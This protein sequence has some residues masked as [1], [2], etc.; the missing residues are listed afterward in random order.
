MSKNRNEEAWEALFAKWEIPARVA[1]EGRFLISADQIREYREPRLMAK[2]D[3]RVNLPQ[4]F[5]E[6]G[7]A[8]LPVS[9]GDY[10]IGRLRRIAALRR[11]S[12][13]CAA[14]RCPLRWKAFRRQV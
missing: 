5:A 11:T 3:H 4:I 13:R 10:V 2:F 1:A 7:L 12:R 9:R 6:N 8:I 14:F